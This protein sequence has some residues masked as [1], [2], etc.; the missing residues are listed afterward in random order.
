MG[1]SQQSASKPKIT[2]I[3]LKL[4]GYILAWSS[5]LYNKLK[6]YIWHCPS[7]RCLKGVLEEE[8]GK[9]QRISK[10]KIN[11][12]TGN[13][14]GREYH[15]FLTKET[16]YHHTSFRFVLFFLPFS[17]FLSA[18]S[19]LSGGIWAGKEKQQ[20][21]HQEK[22]VKPNVNVWNTKSPFTRSLPRQCSSTHT[23][24]RNICFTW[25]SAW[26]PLHKKLL[27]IWLLLSWCTLYI[28][29]STKFSWLWN[30][31]VQFRT[32][33]LTSSLLMWSSK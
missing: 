31:K 16:L 1:D 2:I 4:Q 26:S 30:V 14:L 20:S 11:E 17:L 24:L 3:V 9:E 23:V 19:S 29:R 10:Q 15:D 7:P 13:T 8:L 6:K 27:V 5:I 25:S 22:N 12:T 28:N 21:I 18:G 32:Q 33:V